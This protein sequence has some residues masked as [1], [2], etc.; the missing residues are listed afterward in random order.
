MSLKCTT[1]FSKKFSIAMTV[2]KVET[3]TKGNLSKAL[4]RDNM[5]FH[6]VVFCGMGES[7]SPFTMV[8]QSGVPKLLL[9]VANKPLVQYVLEW[10]DEAP[11][12]QVTVICDNLD[13]S[14][15]KPFV[16]GYVNG[17]RN[18]DLNEIS[19][20]TCL[21][22]NA[23]SKTTG[24]IIQ[25]IKDQINSDFVV[26]PCDFITDLPPQVLI[27]AYRNREDDDLGLTVFYNNNFDLVDKK[28]LK[29]NYTVYSTE[30]DGGQFLL[31]LYSKEEVELQKALELRTQMIWRFPRA[32][33][34]TKLLDSFIYFCSAKVLDIVSDEFSRPISRPKAN[35]SCTKIIRDLARRSWKHA[36]TK[37][38][39]GFFVLPKQ[40]VFARCNNLSVYLEA[41]TY[42]M[43]LRAQKNHNQP[44][45]PKEKGAATIGA[46]SMVGTDTVVGERTSVKRTVVGNGCTIGKRCRLTGCIVMDKVTI[47]DDVQLENCIIGTKASIH[48]KSKLVNCNVE[49]GYVMARSVQSKGETIVSLEDVHFGEGQTL[50][51]DE[52]SDDDDDEDDSDLGSEEFDEYDEEDYSEDDLFAR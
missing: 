2:E 4:T 38:T 20:M 18:A 16:E 3:F 23:E 22:V 21:G 50:M 48:S 31:D 6:V 8:K 47:G 1:L 51:Y 32:T 11:F 52:L 15:M 35:K 24:E 49:G 25:S 30:E 9:P 14:V 13:L 41:N 45:V 29:T 28:L 36:Q 37:E 34:S 43:K 33:V 10:C 44:A 7:M 46:D 12:R 19:K 26:L 27:E 5:E 40:S 17:K 42:F 39:M